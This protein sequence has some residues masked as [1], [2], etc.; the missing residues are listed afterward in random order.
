LVDLTAELPAPAIA[1]N[2]V[3]VPCLDL[4]PVASRALLAAARAI[5]EQRRY[6]PVLVACAL[7]YSRSAA[8]VAAWLRHSGQ[9][10]SLDEAIEQV[11]R[12]RPAVVLGPCWLAALA[13]MEPVSEEAAP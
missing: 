4:V 6:G 2:Y 3:G 7:G 1:R 9:H 13:T 10:G 12:Q 5:E 11:R 8:A